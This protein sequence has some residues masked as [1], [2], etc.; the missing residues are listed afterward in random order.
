V[1]N[2][3]GPT[4]GERAALV[5]EPAAVAGEPL[6]AGPQAAETGRLW[7]LLRSGRVLQVLLVVSVTANLAFAGTFE[8]ALP[9]LAHARFGAAGYGALIACFGAGAVGGTLAAAWGG[10]LRRPAVVACCSCLLAAVSAALLPFLG[11]LVGASAA[12]LVLGACSGFGNVTMITPLQRW[13]PARLLGRVM[14]LVMLASMGTFPVSVAVSGVLVRGLGPV[15][16][17]PVAG[18]GLALAI[19]GALSQRE[20]RDFGLAN[21]PG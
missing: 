11:G 19:L 9:A 12:S 20:L 7:Q 4:T 13:A 14:S 15:A 16:F 2:A 17:F 10:N 6:G 3:T 5:G 18:L 8:V 21:R 1:L